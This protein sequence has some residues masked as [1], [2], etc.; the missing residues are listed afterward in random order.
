MVAMAMA[1]PSPSRSSAHDFLYDEEGALC[2][3]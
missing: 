1:I 2:G 3:S